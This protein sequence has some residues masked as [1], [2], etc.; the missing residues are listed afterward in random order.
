M[1]QKTFPRAVA[2]FG[3]PWF[4]A[5]NIPIRANIVGPPSVATRIKARFG[6]PNGTI[7]AV[8]GSY[9]CAFASSEQ[10]LGLPPDRTQAR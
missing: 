4:S 5:R 2:G 10:L 3:L 7:G 8:V 6:E 9:G 1:T